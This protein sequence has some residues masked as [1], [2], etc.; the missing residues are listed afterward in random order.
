MKKLSL[1][2]LFVVGLSVGSA[3][4]IQATPITVDNTRWYT[5]FAGL[6]GSS[7]AFAVGASN[8][9]GDNPGD[10]PWTYTAA[11]ATEVKIT[12][13]ATVGD[14]F[15]LYDFGAFIGDTSTVANDGTGTNHNDPNLD[16]ADPILSHGSFVLAAGS[17]SLT[18][19]IIQNALPPN[20]EA[21]GYFRVDAVS[22]VPEPGTMLL[23]GSGVLGLVALRR[24]LKK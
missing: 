2:L 12:D 11:T 24:K 20:N 23:L 14:I 10:P 13:T 4:M 16:Y 22:S 21:I 18:I 3:G 5:F 1:V 7:N 6:A 19:E 15:R 8:A 17:H 9:F